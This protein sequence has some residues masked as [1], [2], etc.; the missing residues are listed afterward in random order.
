MRHDGSLE[1]VLLLVR[2]L[3]LFS[4]IAP[5]PACLS[6]CML[7]QATLCDFL[8]HVTNSLSLQQ[9]LA[10]ARV[11]T[12]LTTSTSF[13]FIYFHLSRYVRQQDPAWQLLRTGR[14]TTSK[15]RAALGLAEVGGP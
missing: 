2:L 7:L 12:S 8:L 1:L 13:F 4:C 5:L 3:Q 6:L 11:S 15:L 14:L 10:R 9:E